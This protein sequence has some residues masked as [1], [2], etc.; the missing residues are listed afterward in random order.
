MADETLGVFIHQY[1]ESQPDGEV[2]FIWQGGEPTLMGIPFF[3]KAI[4]YQKKFGRPGQVIQ[5]A[6]QTNGLLLN[7]DWLSL[8]NS[9][10]PS[11][12]MFILPLYA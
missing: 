1:L 6:I 11:N 2:N 9:S 8:P 7:E 3:V 12:I 5:N 10:V 4:E